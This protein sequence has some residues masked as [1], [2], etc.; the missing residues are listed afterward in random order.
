[1]SVSKDQIDLFIKEFHQQPFV[2]YWT[3]YSWVKT[4]AKKN[5]FYDEGE[6]NILMQTAR[7]EFLDRTVVT[8]SH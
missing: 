8:P 5:R 6:V 3:V 1:M 2:Y 4:Y 7:S